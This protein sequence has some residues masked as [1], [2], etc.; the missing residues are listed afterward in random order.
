M[1]NFLKKVFGSPTYK[2]G[3]LYQPNDPRN[4]DIAQVQKPVEI[5]DSYAS[6]F[7]VT[8]IKDQGSN[9]S[10]VGWSFA[11]VAEYILNKRGNKVS[12]DGNKLYKKAKLEDGIPDIQGTFPPVMAKIVTRDG[13]ED[14][15][16][17]THKVSNGYAFVPTN[18]FELICQ[19]I[20]QN[21]VLSSSFVIDTNWFLGLIGKLLQ[22]IGGHAVV[23]NGYEKSPVKIL[24]GVN[25]WGIGWIG[26]IA[27]ML[28]RNVSQGH[29]EAK[30][31]D[32]KDQFLFLIALTP[33]PKEVLDNVIINEY[34]FFYNMSFGDNSFNVQKLQE[35]LVK[36]GYLLAKPNGNFGPQTRKAVMDYQI[37]NGIQATGF[38]GMLTRQQLNK[39]AIDVI[40]LFAKAIQEHEGYFKGSRSF[41]NNSPANFKLGGGL[42]D[43]M[44]SLGGTSLDPQGFVIF[45]TYEIG[46]KALCT[47]LTDAC[48]GGLRSYRPTMSLKKFFE[49]YAPSS[50]NNDPLRY[51]QQVAKKIGC[52]VDTTLIELL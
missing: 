6:A 49:V 52:S 4:I 31:D 34:R 26:R 5:P 20:Y 22:S 24:K 45:P 30:Y 9:P 18:D 48:K 37:A 32:V 12:I 36:E 44:K 2:T 16:G 25:S 11:Q 15:Q 51:A 28:D 35:R 7:P 13:V 41:R 33:I 29:F 8:G 23:L 46:F 14:E 1:F 47:F 50:D 38:V 19:S 39:K 3:A 10:C 40:P 27:S 43:Y 42:T 17:V 21:G